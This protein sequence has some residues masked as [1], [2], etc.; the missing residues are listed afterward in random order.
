[1]LAASYSPQDGH[2]TP[3][4]VVMGY[5]Y[6]ARQ[7]GAQLLTG[8]EVD[9]IERR[10]GRIRRSTPAT[11]T[12]RTDTVI[13]AAGAWSRRRA[14]SSPASSSPSRRCA[15]RCSSPSRWTTSR[16]GSR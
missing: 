4:A 10:D 12:V 13:C 16:S 15:A 6:A 11:M 8:H 9:A 14:A 1:M 7:L 3:E 2:A 5:A